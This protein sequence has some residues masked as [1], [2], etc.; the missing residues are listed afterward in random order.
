VAS[1]TAQLAD[2]CLLPGFVGTRAPDWVRRRAAAGLG[3]VVLYGRNVESPEQLRRLTDDLHSERP[4]LLVS[5]DEEGGDV[6]RLEVRTGSS[7]PGNLALGQAGDLELT[8]AVAFAMGSELAATGIDLD[9]AP[10]ADV[11]S[12]PANPV[13]GVRSFGAQPALVA[14]H[15]AAFV[16]GLQGAGVAACAKHF[17]GHGD[18]STDSHLEL[19]VAAEDPRLG[20]L[21][22]FRAAIAAGVRSIMSAHLLV[23]VLDSVPATLSHRIL[24]QLLRDELGFGGLVI[25]DG[26]E[27]RAISDGV[28]IAEGAVGA[29][30]AGCDALC[31]GGGLAEESIVDELRDAILEAVRS[32]RL[33]EERLAE[34][35]GRVDSLAAWR[36]E[37]Q[38]A[39]AAQ[40]GVGLEAA[41]RAVQVEGPVRAGADALVV[42]LRP[43]ASMAVGAVAWGI[44]PP[45]LSFDGPPVDVDGVLRRAEGRGLVLVVR[46]LHRHAWQADAVEALLARR[47]DAVLVE[48]GLPA[49]RPAR[50]GSYVSTFGAGRVNGQAAAERVLS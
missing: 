36:A 13:I 24:T 21:E 34:A 5:I 22:P 11:N 19:P 16:E 28:G 29:L 39:P 9:L 41:R 20:A 35:A 49:R 18:T 26:L 27:M 44:A 30:V 2:R 7:Y 45:A 25:T 12:N 3:G 38:P 8:R 4:E 1:T 37:R 6:T 48:M 31:I 42:Q 40:R 17:P 14:A 23:P 47:P 10:D 15:T 43:G 46:D 50:A 32:G 33:S